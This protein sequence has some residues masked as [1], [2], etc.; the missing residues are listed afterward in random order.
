MR[1]HSGPNRNDHDDRAQKPRARW[2]PS[3]RRIAAVAASGA[4]MAVLIAVPATNRAAA[5][6]GIAAS[7]ASRG[8]PV[9]RVL[10]EEQQGRIYSTATSEY[11]QASDLLGDLAAVSPQPLKANLLSLVSTFAAPT[12]DVNAGKS[13]L[14]AFQALTDSPVLINTEQAVADELTQL[15]GLQLA[16]ATTSNPTPTLIPDV[17]PGWTGQGSIYTNN[18]FPYLLDTSG[19]NYWGFNSPAIPGGR[20]EIHGQFPYARYFSILPN[21]INTDNLQQQTDAFIQPD[22]GS[23]NPFRGPMTPGEGRYYTINFVFSSPPANPAPNTSYV[24]LTQN[25]KPNPY[26]FFVYRIYESDFGNLPNS[27]GVPLPAITYYNADGTVARSY[28][29]CNPYPDGPPP[30]PARIQSFPAL[31]IP[32]PHTTADPQISVSSDYHL[33]VNLLANPDVLYLGAFY[34]EHF[35]DVFVVHAKA[36]TTPDTPSV[37][38]YTPG[39]DTRGWSVCSYNFYAGYANAC[40]A[41]HQVAVDKNGYYTIVI[42]TTDNRPKN[43]DAAHGVTWINWGPYLDGQITWRIF[44]A[45]SPLINQIKA[46][47]TTGHPSEAAAPYIPQFSYCTPGAFDA[48]HCVTQGHT[49]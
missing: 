28:P 31:P 44:L 1:E 15:C 37:P 47:I 27:A 45:D 32:G 49:N 41:D 7:Q 11:Q 36:L 34:S 22:P 23:G 26:V 5:A 18:E 46:G 38:V 21:D 25:G 33:P 16:P 19:A 9:C 40:Y 3:R 30:A 42:S 17:C 14:P 4:S 39:F 24:G 29:E 20:I 6:G 2:S 10:A 13:V 35:G 48:G 43:A 8:A 12:A